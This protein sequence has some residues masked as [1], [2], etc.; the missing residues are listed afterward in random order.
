METPIR[1]FGRISRHGVR[2]PQIR[3]DNKASKPLK[4]TELL[5]PVFAADA[6]TI[7]RSPSQPYYT[8]PMSVPVDRILSGIP[9]AAPKET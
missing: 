6:K 2:T 3:I 9:A 7:V 1:D 5:I 8:R 4:G